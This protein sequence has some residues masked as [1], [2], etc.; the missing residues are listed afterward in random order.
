MLAWV[1]LLEVAPMRG[2]RE[3]QVTML[4]F[5]DLETRVPSGHPLRRIKALADE[6][7]GRLSPPHPATACWSYPVPRA[8]SFFAISGQCSKRDERRTGGY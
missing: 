1:N 6:V 3:P 7:L 2:K 4:A 8:V 5:V